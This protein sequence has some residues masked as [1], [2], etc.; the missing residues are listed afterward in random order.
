MTAA[1]ADLVGQG[2]GTPGGVWGH[3][4]VPEC[5]QGHLEVCEGTWE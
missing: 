3:L 1:V 4:G 2:T 5:T